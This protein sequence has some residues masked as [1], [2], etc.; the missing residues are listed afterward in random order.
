MSRADPGTASGT[1]SET[2]SGVDPDT[3]DSH[4]YYE[5]HPCGYTARAD[6]SV[7]LCPR[8]GQRIE[9]TATGQ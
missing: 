2:T 7:G 6:L 8:C 4:R 3:E 9:W 5:C 1:D